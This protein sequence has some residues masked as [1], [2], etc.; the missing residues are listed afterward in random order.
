MEMTRTFH[1]VGQGAFYTERFEAY[2]NGETFTIV[3]DC[4]STTLSK[5]VMGSKIQGALPKGSQIDIFFIS[6]FHAD[7]ING[8][9]A[10]KKHYKIK[11]VILPLLS[12]EAKILLKVAYYLD[13]KSSSRLPYDQFEKLIDDPASFF[14]ENE[15][16][17]ITI[18]P[19]EG[20]PYTQEGLPE[21][22]DISQITSS[23]KFASGTLLYPFQD[24]N[25]F[26]I[27]FNYKQDTRRRLFMNAIKEKGLS[28]EDIDT[29]DKIAAQKQVL[30][31]AYDSIEGDLNSNSMI[32]FS[33]GIDK[34]IY[35][36]HIKRHSTT[37]HGYSWIYAYSWVDWI[38][39][40][41]DRFLL[42]NWG[43]Y[44]SI[45]SGCL[46]LGDI[47]LNERDLIKDI[48]HR[49][50]SF[51]PNL[52]TIQVPHHGSKHNFNRSIC[53]LENLHLAILSFGT[54]NRYGHPADYVIA[55]IWKECI[56]PCLVTEDPSSIVVQ[57]IRFHR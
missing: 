24:I 11:T 9:E 2:S 6:H 42:H 28:E 35:Y 29:I 23:K 43:Y 5:K 57:Q 12:Y 8:I 45:R 17:V 7:H 16:K 36:D 27:P 39:L 38:C 41:K 49:L 1:P 40:K 44:T 10:L 25:W 33:G 26:F 31:E 34:R 55:E 15:T 30:K 4:G 53:G 52:G 56:F 18:A 37:V 21:A 32:L 46:Y 47:D 22:I 50:D 54:K 48:R 3:Y 13:Q 51:L 14:G 20:E 19:V